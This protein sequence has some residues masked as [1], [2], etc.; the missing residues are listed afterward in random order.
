MVS[1]GGR[2]ASSKT[3]YCWPGPSTSA[4]VMGPK[5]FSSSDFHS[6]IQTDEPVI[7]V[8]AAQGYGRQASLGVQGREGWGTLFLTGV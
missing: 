4:T 6:H 1:S 7:R 5:V 8:W 2:A 3:G